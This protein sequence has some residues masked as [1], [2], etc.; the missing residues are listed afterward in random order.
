[1]NE[2]AVQL[3]LNVDIDVSTKDKWEK[4]LDLIAGMFNIPCAL[5]MHVLSNEIEVFA[6]STNP[7]NIYHIGQKAQLGTGLYSEAVIQTRQMLN[8]SNALKQ[9]KWENNPDIAYGMISY[10][11]VPILWP[12]KDVFGT[13]CV[14]DKRERIFTD[15][16]INLLILIA[17][18]IGDS[19]KSLLDREKLNLEVELQSKAALALRES[20][21]RFRKVYELSPSAIM[22]TTADE[23]RF[24]DVNDACL[25]LFGVNKQELLGKKVTDFPMYGDPEERNVVVEKLQQ[26]RKIRHHFSD[27]KTSKGDDLELDVSVDIIRI[28]EKDCLISTLFDLTEQNML[29]RQLKAVNERLRL[30]ADSAGIGIWDWDLRNDLLEWDKNMY[31]LYQT[32]DVAVNYQ[33]WRS[34]VHPEGRE[35]FEHD[36]NEAL[37]DGSLYTSQ[38][39]LLLPE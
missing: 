27:K 14:L 29:A 16:E 13:I 19:L 22:I 18:I 15:N 1:M 24:V 31:R 8:I 9:S 28:G 21:E 7:D 35:C 39:R 38:F 5:V 34:R 23:G 2:S 3:Q 26:H 20:E 10:L 30:A 37:L 33:V 12:N 6:R 25:K 11:G 17:T 32:E 4:M 36:L